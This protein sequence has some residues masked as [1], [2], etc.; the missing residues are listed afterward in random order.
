MRTTPVWPSRRAFAAALGVVL[1]LA[2]VAGAK[3]Y[4]TRFVANNCN[5]ND[6][7]PTSYFTRDGSTTVALYARWEGY[8]W[9]GGYYPLSHI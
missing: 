7:Q 2:V 9:G 1:T 3:A 5:Y 8:Q 6:P 4:H